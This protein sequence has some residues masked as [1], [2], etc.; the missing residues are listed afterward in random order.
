MIR[1]EDIMIYAIYFKSSQ[2][3]VFIGTL[4]NIMQWLMFDIANK[5]NIML[6]FFRRD[7]KRVFNET[8]DNDMNRLNEHIQY[9]Y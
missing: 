8:L 3:I 2:M 6:S 5:R 7:S 9:M 4:F 1:C